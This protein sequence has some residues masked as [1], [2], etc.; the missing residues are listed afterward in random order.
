[1]ENDDFARHLDSIWK[2]LLRA[3]MSLQIWWV[4][5]NADDAPTWERPLGRFANFFVPDIRAH[6]IVAVV[7]LYYPFDGRGDTDNFKRTLRLARKY[8]LPAEV[9]REAEQVIREA[10]PVAEK[11]G[12]LRH[13]RFAHLASD[14]SAD[15]VFSDAK[16]T[17]DEMKWLLDTCFNVLDLISRAYNNNTFSRSFSN[18]EY[19]MREMLDVIVKD[20]DRLLAQISPEPA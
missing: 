12:L 19:D 6:L 1:M 20:Y 5:R 18:V 2:G 13:K 9:I 11:V 8:N 10:R 7:A 17:P 3:G 4:Y 15:D 14:T 16:L